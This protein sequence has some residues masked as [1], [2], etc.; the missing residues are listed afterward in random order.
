MQNCVAEN[1]DLPTG[2]V[3][4][5]ADAHRVN[6]SMISRPMTPAGVQVYTSV[7]PSILHQCVVPLQSNLPF[8]VPTQGAYRVVFR[9]PDD[10][11]A[12]QIRDGTDRVYPGSL[13]RFLLREHEHVVVVVVGEDHFRICRR[14]RLRQCLRASTPDTVQKERVTRRAHVRH[15]FPLPN[16]LLY[17]VV[18]YTAIRLLC[19]DFFVQYMQ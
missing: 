4:V 10:N 6:T 16:M 2:T 7:L 19:S 3:V 13:P 14:H 18:A 17:R 15:R 11:D 5:V 9:F 12:R 8:P 1:A